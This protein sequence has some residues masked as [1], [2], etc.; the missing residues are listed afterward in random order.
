MRNPRVIIYDDDTIILDMLGHFFVKRGYEVCSYNSPTVCPSH[1]GPADSCEN[2]SPCADVIISDYKMPEMTG[3]ERLQRQS[4]R[5]CTVESKRKA[6][7]SGHAEEGLMAQ[8][9][10]LG[11]RFF[12]KPFVLS[13]LS[14]WLSECEKHFDLSQQLH[15]RRANS[16]YAFKQ[17]LNIVCTPSPHRKNLLA[18]PLI[19]AMTDLDY[20]YSILSTQDRGKDYQGPGSPS[21]TRSCTVVQ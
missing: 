19:K 21:S 18:S 20:A 13:E 6:I 16:R 1:E 8:C 12:E 15:D 17:R 7:M 4:K 2:L 11:C 10:D 9:R 14:D 3:I 5:G